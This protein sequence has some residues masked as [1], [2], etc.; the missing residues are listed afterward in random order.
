MKVSQAVAERIKEI[1][2]EKEMTQY[3]LEINSGLPKGTFLSLMYARYKGVNLTTLV[4][5]IRTLGLTIDEFFASP[6]FN[7]DNL[8][9]D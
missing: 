8:D 6:L 1:L 7:D 5:I 3:R 4:V 9:I 2:A